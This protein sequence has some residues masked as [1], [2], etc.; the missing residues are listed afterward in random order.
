MIK[1]KRKNVLPG[2]WQDYKQKLWC[3]GGLNVKRKGKA[4]DSDADKVTSY[5][6]PWVHEIQISSNNKYDDILPPFP[7]AESAYGPFD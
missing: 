3:S 7:K 6:S 5:G 2:Y 1:D 4:Q